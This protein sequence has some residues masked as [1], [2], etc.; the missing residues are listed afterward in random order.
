MLRERDGYLW[1]EIKSNQ[2]TEA[3]VSA[4]IY[5]IDNNNTQ[6]ELYRCALDISASW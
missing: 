1:L 2:S 5:D 4:C 3:D 6:I